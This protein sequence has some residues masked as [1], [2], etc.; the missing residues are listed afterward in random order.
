MLPGERGDYTST[1]WADPDIEY[2]RADGPDAGSWR[3]L[4]GL[5]EGARSWLSA[6]EEY[7]IEV[8]EYRELDEERLL[9]LTHGTGAEQRAE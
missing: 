1:E 3:G 7:R 6:W 9:A 4:T 8:D 5:A 2:V